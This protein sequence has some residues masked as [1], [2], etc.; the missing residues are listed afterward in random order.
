MGSTK[1]DSQRI[2]AVVGGSA[3]L[4]F[5]LGFNNGNFDGSSRSLQTLY[6]LEFLLSTALAGIVISKF[7]RRYSTALGAK[8]LALTG[9]VTGSAIFFFYF[10]LTLA[11][12][13]LL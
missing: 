10:A 11:T 2:G 3:A 5:M 13:L 8:E 12:Q 9:V 7:L 6:F 4:V 1:E